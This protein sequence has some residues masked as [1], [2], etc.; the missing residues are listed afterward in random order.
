M[1]ESDQASYFELPREGRVM[2]LVCDDCD[3]TGDGVIMK[4]EWNGAKFVKK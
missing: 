4:F 2:K 3:A 1:P